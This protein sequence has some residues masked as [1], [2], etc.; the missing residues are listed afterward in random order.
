MRHHALSVL[1]IMTALTIPAVT[2]CRGTEPTYTVVTTVVTEAGGIGNPWK[3]A[4]TLEEAAYGANLNDFVIDE[5]ALIDGA[6]LSPLDYK[7][8]D[9]IA[10]AKYSLSGIRVDIRKSTLE[11]S[12][13]SDISGT[14]NDYTYSWPVDVNGMTVNCSSYVKGKPQKAFWVNG[15]LCYSIC[16][17]NRNNEETCLSE[18][19]VRDLVNAVR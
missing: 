4:L 10:E 16:V 14:Y 6:T 5:K 3:D 2:A 9:C 7:Y 15:E 19:A 8:T 18:A 17:D 12:P 13:S 11:Y 1:C